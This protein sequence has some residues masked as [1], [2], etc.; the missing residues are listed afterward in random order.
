MFNGAPVTDQSGQRDANRARNLKFKKKKKLLQHGEQHDN[1]NENGRIR[2]KKKRIDNETSWKVVIIA[3]EK[4][5]AGKWTSS[6]DRCCFFFRSE[7]ELLKEHRDSRR[8]RDL[9]ITTHTSTHRCQ[10]RAIA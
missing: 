3:N 7:N 6:R 8:R 9:K 2:K 1:F 4:K 5:T 10:V